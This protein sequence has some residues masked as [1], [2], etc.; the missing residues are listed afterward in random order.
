MIITWKVTTKI[1]N[2]LAPGPMWRPR[3]D[4]AN[5]LNEDVTLHRD[6]DDKA[7][8]MTVV[9]FFCERNNWES[10]KIGQHH[11]PD[12]C[13]IHTMTWFLRQTESH[14]PTVILT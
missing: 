2:L 12:L 11:G 8:A 7:V 14:R 6:N 9:A 4:I 1:I 13:P 10:I 3:W 5:L